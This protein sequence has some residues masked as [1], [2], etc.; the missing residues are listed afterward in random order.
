MSDDVSDDK[1]SG[2]LVAYEREELQFP[3]YLL[4][5]L[6]LIFI[7]AGSLQRLPILSALAVAPLAGFFYNLPLL[8]TGRWRLGGGQYGF[9]LEGL[10]VVDWRAIDG[11]DLVAK[12]MRGA[13]GH[14]LRIDLKTA[15][16]QALILDW[17]R[18]SFLR[19][20]MRLPWSWAGARTIR[21]PLDIMDKPA[22]E[23]HATLQRMW[24]Y[25]R[26][27]NPPPLGD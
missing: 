21:I 22:E 1:I 4:A 14:E 8:E 10:G 7:V 6:A 17:R 13:L 26:G 27:Q 9:L 12:D 20:L 2:Y 19:S 18:R 15:V 3:V 25:Y 24:R 11:I 5:L 23:I 16:T